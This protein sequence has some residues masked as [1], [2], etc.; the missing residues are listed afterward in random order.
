MHSASVASGIF[1]G[2][3]FHVEIDPES[4]RAI[5]PLP[6]CPQCGGLARPNILMFGDWGWDSART[7]RQ[8]R[9][10]NTWIE[11]LDDAR[12]VVIECGAGQAVPTVRITCQNIARQ[13]RRH[14]GADQSARARCTRRPCLASHGSLECASALDTRLKRHTPSEHRCDLSV[15]CVVF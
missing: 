5:H 11:S 7:D 2:E 15:R 1:S 9:R 13:K 14:L 10:M 6:S 12:L 8:M 3:S 4:M